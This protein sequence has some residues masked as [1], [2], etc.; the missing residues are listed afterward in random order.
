TA[1]AAGIGSSTSPRRPS[2]RDSS[3]AREGRW[4]RS[5]VSPS[6]SP[7]VVV[8][9]RSTSV[10]YRLS[11]PTKHGCS[12]VDHPDNTTRSPV[13]NGSSVPAWPVRA[14][15]RR[16]SC[17]ITAKED[18]PAG[19]S[20]STIP[21]GSSARGGIAVPMAALLCAVLGADEVRDLVD[22]ELAREARRLAMPPALGLS[23]DRRDVDFVRARAQ[24]HA[25]RGPV[26]ARRL[27]DERRDDRALD[28]AKVV[29]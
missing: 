13:A 29:D 28:R 22:G 7:V 20:T 19:L 9:E 8:A 10:T 18:G 17:A 1:E 3:S 27:A 21:A 11:S 6:G 16:R 4:R 25:A 14:R 24:G 23:R 12:L 2:S 5:T 15:V 26:G